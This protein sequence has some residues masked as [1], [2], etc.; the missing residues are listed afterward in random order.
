MK[1]PVFLNVNCFF[2]YYTKHFVPFYYASSLPTIPY[3]ILC[4]ALRMPLRSLVNGPILLVSRTWCKQYLGQVVTVKNRPLSFHSHG[5][6][7]L[8]PLLQ[9]TPDCFP[10]WSDY[11]LKKC[12]YF[13]TQSLMEARSQ[14]SLPWDMAADRISLMVSLVYSF[15]MLCWGINTCFL[16]G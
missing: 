9:R 16:P 2:F 10:Q 4:S 7:L 11:R 12:V 1:S 3:T 6:L 15:L 14:P 8:A 5:L 13:F